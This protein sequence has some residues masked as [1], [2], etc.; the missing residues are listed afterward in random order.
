[1]NGIVL[2]TGSTGFVGRQILRALAARGVP[3]RAV[4]RCGRQGELNE[5]G[6]LETVVETDDM[7]AESADWWSRVCD[8]VDIVIHAAWYTEPGQYLGSAKN[9]DCLTG[10]IE[11]AKGAA[12]S[13]V[14]RFVGIGTCFEYDLSAGR[15]PVDTPLQPLTPYAS[16]KAAAFL[17]LSQWLPRQSVEF[18]WCRLFYLYGEREDPRRLVSYLRSNLRNGMAAKLTHGSQIRDYLDV[19]EA[20]RFIVEV[21]MSARQGPVN[22]CS[23]TPITVR[24]LAERIA[25]EYGRRDLLQF[26]AR[27]DNLADP[28]C[29]VGVRDMT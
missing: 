13:G 21:A 17:V 24:E 5:G 8:G 10:T 29:V 26:G 12:R 1:M 15:L 23:G 20:G 28:S 22:I 25:D 7:F 19:A 14:R 9:L 2:L 16:A 4:I 27:A 6:S 11:M 3:V 18:A